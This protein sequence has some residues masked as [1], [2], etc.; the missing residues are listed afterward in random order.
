[1][2]ATNDAIYRLEALRRHSDRVAG[3]LRADR[4]QVALSGA[5]ER[6]RRTSAIRSAFDA[7]DRG[8]KRAAKFVRNSGNVPR[9][10]LESTCHALPKFLTGGTSLYPWQG[11]DAVGSVSRDSQCNAWPGHSISDKDG[12]TQV[13]FVPQRAYPNASPRDATEFC[14]LWYRSVRSRSP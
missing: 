4:L 6:S 1:M 8:E 14:S 10:L 12:N 5:T 7:D 11:Y 13:R 2:P 9:S 3:A